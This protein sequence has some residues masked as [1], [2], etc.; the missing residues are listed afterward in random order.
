M[1]KQENLFYEMLPALSF[2][3]QH[4]DISIKFYKTLRVK[5]GIFDTNFCRLPIK[6]FDQ[7]QNDEAKIHLDK[8]I[9]LQDNLSNN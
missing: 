8:I 2:A 9:K 1:K 5:E 7:F 6:D 4:I 3:H